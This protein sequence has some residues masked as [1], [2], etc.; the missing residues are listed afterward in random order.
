MIKSLQAWI[1]HK[2]WSGDTSA[3]VSFYTQELGIIQCLCKGGRTPKKQSLLQAFTPL[4]IAVDER[5]ERYYLRSIESCAPSLPLLGDALFSGLYINELLYYT[6]KPNDPDADLFAAYVETLTRLCLLQPNEQLESLLRRFEWTLLH[7]CGASPSLQHEVST[8][9]L[10]SQHKRY[11]FIA[12][13]GFLL[14]AQGIPGAHILALAKD[15]LDEADCLKSAKRIM[16]QAIDHLLDGREIK[17]RALY[18][19]SK[20]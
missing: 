8:G 16:R 2:Y 5:R 11:Q 7:A 4:W 18:A 6:L 17:A 12:G 3:Q 9:E 20:V 1:L 10:I 19:A 13:V 14:A 15:N